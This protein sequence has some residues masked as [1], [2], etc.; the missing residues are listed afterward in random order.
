VTA[1]L[2]A[3]AVGDTAASEALFEAV[4]D[5]LR[6]MAGAAFGRRP[7]HTLQPTALVH[8]AW[9]K[10]ENH[11][12]DFEGR[13]HFL[14]TAA[15]AMRQLLANYAEA[16]RT[17]KRDGRRVELGT[18]SEVPADPTDFFDA[19]ELHE[20]LEKLAGLKERH[21]RVVELRFLCSLSIT[22]TA[23]TLGVSHTTVEQDWAMARAW[24]R[25]ELRT[26]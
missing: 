8:E 15:R 5:Q 19:V 23:E 18:L 3:A 26:D 7:G 21:A 6:A 10:L 17:A 9:L 14:R 13:R 16:G 12:G 2:R 1:L 24:L 22:Q 11:L 25:R 20:A 4:Y